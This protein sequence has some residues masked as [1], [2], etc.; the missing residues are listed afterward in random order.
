MFIPAVTVIALFVIDY[1]LPRQVHEQVHEHV[2]GGAAAKVMRKA[3]PTWKRSG[4]WTLVLDLD[5]TL[6]HTNGEVTLVRPFTETF[7][8]Q[9][10]DLFSKVV[11]F[12]AGTKAYADPVLDMLE[13]LASVKFHARLYRN[14]CTPAK[15][16]SGGWVKDLRKVQANLTRLLIVD[17]TPSSYSLQPQCGVPIPSYWGQTNDVELMLILSTLAVR[18]KEGHIKRGR[19]LE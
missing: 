7:L 9:V 3:Q 1:L 4:G 8:A 11:V 17:N 2:G 15:D 10:F 19:N 12:T 5:E 13:E 6:V 18:V 14:S 16:G